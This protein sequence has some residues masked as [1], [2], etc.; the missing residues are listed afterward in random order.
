LVIDTFH[1]YVGGSTLESIQALDPS[2][3]FIFHIND[4][5]D[6]PRAE[7]QDRHRLLPG[8]GI[9]PVKEIWSALQ[10]IG[11]DQMASVEIFRPEYWEWDPMELAVR[12]KEAA[13]N[14]LGLA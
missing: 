11:Y 1:F 5:E 10:A 7:L 12:A 13:E 6:L 9:L 4:A 14:V 2:R 3:V 8:L